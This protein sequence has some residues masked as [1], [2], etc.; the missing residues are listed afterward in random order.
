MRTLLPLAAALFAVN[1]SGSPTAPTAIP[2]QGSAASSAPLANLRWDV[3]APG[4]TPKSPPSPLPDPEQARLE[5]G[6]HGTIVAFWPS[7]RTG[8]LHATLVESE[9]LLLVCDWEIADL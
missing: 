5:P 3:V 7:Y 8:L 2:T 9:Q 6:P 1:C 4:C